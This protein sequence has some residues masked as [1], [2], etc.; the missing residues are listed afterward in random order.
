MGYASEMTE[1]DRLLWSLLCQRDARRM[2]RKLRRDS[3]EHHAARLAAAAEESATV[4]GWPAY[5]W[6][7]LSAAQR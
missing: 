1:R 4:Y 6:P 5:G 2:Q 7:Q 3:M